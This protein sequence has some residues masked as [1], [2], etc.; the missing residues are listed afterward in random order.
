MGYM[1]QVRGLANM[2]ARVEAA[3]AS[4]MDTSWPC[5]IVVVR[6]S[7]SC[8]RVLLGG[9]EEFPMAMDGTVGV[10]SAQGPPQTRPGGFRIGCESTAV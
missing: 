9:R 3:R 7:G 10:D 6:R 4:A 8:V 1:M 5:W 2:R